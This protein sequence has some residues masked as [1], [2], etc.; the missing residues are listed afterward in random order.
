[1][2]VLLIFICH[3]LPAAQA[4]LPGCCL[5]KVLWTTT[6]YFIRGNRSTDENLILK[7]HHWLFPK[8]TKNF[9]GLSMTLV[10]INLLWD[11]LVKAIVTI[12]LCN[13]ATLWTQHKPPLNHLRPWSE[14]ANSWQM[15]WWLSKCLK[16]MLDTCITI[17]AAKTKIETRHAVRPVCV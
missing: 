1:M 15:A 13:S 12:I 8:M 11:Y 17:M 9:L 7:P 4:W 14:N 10:N 3:S 2:C 5:G 16:K 6:H